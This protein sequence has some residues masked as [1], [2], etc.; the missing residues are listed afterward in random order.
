MSRQFSIASITDVHSRALPT[1]K[2]LAGKLPRP[3]GARGL[4]GVQS[5][6]QR[7]RLQRNVRLR[8]SSQIARVA[9]LDAHALDVCSAPTIDKV[10]YQVII[11]HLC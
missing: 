5:C 9:E 2:L 8:P 1:S 3:H 6:W 10:D 7:P 11:C 4:C